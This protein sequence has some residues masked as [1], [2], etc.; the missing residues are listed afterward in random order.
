MT[1]VRVPLLLMG[2]GDGELGEPWTLAALVCANLRKWLIVGGVE[3]V[4]HAQQACHMLRVTRRS[5]DSLQSSP[6]EYLQVSS[7]RPHPL[8]IA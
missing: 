3:S 5:R 6:Q 2:R 1:G 8:S 4:C 7:H